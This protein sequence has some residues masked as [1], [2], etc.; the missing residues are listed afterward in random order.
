M[1]EVGSWW[2][3]KGKLVFDSLPW[4]DTPTYN[5]WHEGKNDYFGF[6]K[7][8]KRFMPELKNSDYIDFPRGRVLYNEQSQEF[9]CYASNSSVTSSAI[10]RAVI[11]KFR[12]P[13][14]R[15]KLSRMLRY[16]VVH[17][18]GRVAVYCCQELNRAVLGGG[19]LQ[20]MVD[21]EINQWNVVGPG[22]VSNLQP[23][24]WERLRCWSFDGRVRG[25]TD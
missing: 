22:G 2:F 5:G 1:P 9:V 18:C 10:K 24:R 16:I 15:T 6:F 17:D 25:S 14:A 11:R 20:Q 8:L 23:D 21:I 12:L 4:R 13:S 3:I 7:T 19:S